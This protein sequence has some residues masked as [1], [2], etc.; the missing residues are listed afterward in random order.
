LINRHYVLDLMPG[1][2]FAE[3]LV[4][5][6]HDVYAIDWGTP[7]DED[8][9]LAFDTVCDRYLG[10]AVRFAARTAR[11]G[12]V[13]LLGYC[14][15]GTL[16]TIYA[17]R[18]PDSVASLINIAAPIGFH[19]S[20]L[21]SKWTRTMAFSVK[22]LVDGL[23]NIP[24]QLMQ[25]SFHMLRPTLNLFKTVQ[26]LDRISDDEFLDSFAAIET[27]GNDN[28]SFPGECYRRYVED[29]YRKNALLEDTLSISGRPI[30]LH[31][32]DCPTLVVTFEHDHIVPAESAAVLLNH[33]GSTRKERIHLQGGHVG[34]VI[35]K[36]AASGLWLQI[37]RWCFANS[38]IVHGEDAVQRTMSPESMLH[39]NIV[40]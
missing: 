30:S 22:Q 26:L 32:I 39:R 2:S 27:W 1:K 21:L 9:Y 6:G 3:F 36:K 25:A 14:L 11:V 29:L 10:R 37:S 16:T 5:Q 15:G 18:H 40:S 20:G 17:A 24:W 23:G 34:A 4:S 8:R 12:R 7:A 19:D 38:A 13:H 35:S 33:V 28:V 31:D